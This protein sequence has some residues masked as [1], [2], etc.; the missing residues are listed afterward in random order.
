MIPH[1]R[2]KHGKVLETLISENSKLVEC[3]VC[4]CTLKKQNL[5]GHIERCKAKN[6][7]ND[8]PLTRSQE[9][10]KLFYPDGDDEHE[11][12]WRS[13]QQAGAPGLGKRKS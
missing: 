7:D 4:K 11:K 9:L 3:P 2:K 12:R 1:M 8:K 5:D 13:M 10:K 6:I